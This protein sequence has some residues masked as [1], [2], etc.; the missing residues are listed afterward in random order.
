M[1][2][3]VWRCT[4]VAASGASWPRPSSPTPSP[5]STTVATRARGTV[6]AGRWCVH[7]SVWHSCVRLASRNSH[8]R[9]RQCHVAA[10]STELHGR[11]RMQHLP[12]LATPLSNHFPPCC[13]LVWCRSGLSSSWRGLHSGHCWRSASYGGTT[14]CGFRTT[15]LTSEV[16]LYLLD[17]NGLVSALA[18][19]GYSLNVVDTS[20]LFR[21]T[22]QTLCTGK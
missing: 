10:H 21:L 5:S 16:P 4:L 6:S 20:F 8:L 19:D 7:V 13:P 11:H 9:L 14:C 12:L 3:T 17:T 15:L 2:S 1:P 18:I 22:C